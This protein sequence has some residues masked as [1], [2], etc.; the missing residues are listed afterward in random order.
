MKLPVSIA[1][2]L[3]LMQT[4]EKIPFSKLKHVIFD[5]MIENGILKKQ[6]QGR[7]KTL[8]YLTDRN[9]LIAYLQNHFGIDNL[10]NYIAGLQRTDLSRS[11]AVDISSNS[12]V[13][14]IR[15][16]KGFLVN[17]Y[18]PVECILNSKQII[19]QPQEGVF[20]FI[21]DF[22]NFLPCYDITIVG[23]ENPENFRHIQKH[24]KLFDKIQPLFVSRYPQSKDLVRWLQ[25]IPNGY[26]HFGD[27]DFA[28]LNIYVNEFKK[29][30][31][32]KASFF[33]PPD[34]EKILA[35]KGNR[36][37]YNKQTIQFD[38]NTV[39]EESVLFLL[40]LIEKY[41]KGLEQEIYAK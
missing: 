39:K 25:K 16:F 35:A 38:R 33:V 30:L 37:N 24:S 28:G 7:S 1:E 21:Y 34:I 18:H 12:K 41:K 22:E 20:T 15:T 14:S 26:L 10:E 9:K 8:V 11:E 40:D 19:I 31:H 27:F 36:E 29:Y 4:G 6:I 3:I 32:E 5:S 23:I 2:K 17:S 13:K